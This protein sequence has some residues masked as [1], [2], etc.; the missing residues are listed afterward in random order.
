MVNRYIKLQEEYIKDEQRY[1]NSDC[2]M[3]NLRADINQVSEARACQSTGG[4]QANTKCSSG[5]W[6]V[7]GSYRPEVGLL[8]LWSGTR[9]TS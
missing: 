7:Y 3:M 5:Y 2:A 4:D 9:L 1:V 8:R 6:P